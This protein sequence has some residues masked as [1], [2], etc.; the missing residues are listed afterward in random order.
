[1]PLPAPPPL[2]TAMLPGRHLC[3]ET[4]VI[5]TGGGT[6]LGKA[7]AIEFARLGAAVGIVSRSPEHRPPVWRRWRRPEDG[8]LT[9]AADIRDFDQVVAAFDVIE[10]ELGPARACWSTTPLPTSRCR[11]RT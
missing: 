2:G 4:V 8:R 7:I 9:A 1:M 3:R 6:G 5:V 11:P 10:N